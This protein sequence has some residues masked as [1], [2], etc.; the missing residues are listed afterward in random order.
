MRAEVRSSGVGLPA[1]GACTPA[2]LTSVGQVYQPAT[3]AAASIC[4][5]G[6]AA[7]AD[8]TIIPFFASTNNNERAVVNVTATGIVAPT[9][10]L[11]AALSAS[12]PT[13]ARAAAQA[14]G[15]FEARLRV[16][17]RQM[18]R[19]MGRGAARNAIAAVPEVRIS[20]VRTR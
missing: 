11:N 1:A 16:R 8:Y 18:L 6:G 13:L 12:G 10:T 5:D 19:R 7:G 2:P 14:D 3:S 17:E 15:G 4:L 9:A 20:V